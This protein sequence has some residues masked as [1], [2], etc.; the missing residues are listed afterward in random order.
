M[1][2]D[3]PHAPAQVTYH[4]SRIMREH[5]RDEALRALDRA[6]VTSALMGEIG[7]TMTTHEVLGAPAPE[8]P[9][10]ATFGPTHTRRSRALARIRANG[11]GLRMTRE[12]AATPRRGLFSGLAMEHDDD[13]GLITGLEEDE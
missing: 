13:T 2:D 10:G 8:V 5:R 1:S 11:A 9:T 7:L 3:L 12:P 4:E 6:D